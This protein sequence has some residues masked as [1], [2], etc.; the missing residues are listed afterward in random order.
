MKIVKILG[1]G[2]LSLIILIVVVSFFLSSKV[3]VE[4]S[5][6][7]K[8]QSQTV[9]SFLNDLKKWEQWSPFILMDSTN[10]IIYSE[11]TEGLGAWYTWKGKETGEGKITII[12]SAPFTF[13]NCEMDF[14]AMGIA[15]GAFKIDSVT[16]GV[17]LTW[18][19][20]SEGKGI[21]WYFYVVSKYLYMA[22]DK[23][24]GSQFE[25]GLNKV[26]QIAEDVP[27]K[28]TVAGFDVEIKNI[29]NLNVLSIREMVK[30]NVFGKRIGECY[31]TIGQ[32]IDKH[33]IKITSSP[34]IVIHEMM[35]D[36]CDVEFAIP[37]DSTAKGTDKI[38]LN[39]LNATEAVVVKYYGSYNKTAAVYEA[40][41]KFI[42]SKNKKQAG[43]PREVY[44]T[45]PGIEK[46]TAKW[47]T[48]IIFP[49]E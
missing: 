20:D 11:Q 44:I 42:E 7:I 2:L 29:G 26:K 13:M 21:S 14:G 32:Y 23:N 6:E 36:T 3:H 41:K 24:L 48:E 22:M 27:Q 38:L 43:P 1:I 33:K 19:F 9:F 10:K 17:K 30:N 39:K 31:A 49:V 28:E 37:V 16:E 12:Q 15:N 8:A 25:I 45:D 40:A 4:R 46:D 47:L 5:I 18:S 34:L 35:N